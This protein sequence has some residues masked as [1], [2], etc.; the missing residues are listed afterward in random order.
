MGVG[1]ISMGGGGDSA[2][3]GEERELLFSFTHAGFKP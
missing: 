3:E 1:N 2:H